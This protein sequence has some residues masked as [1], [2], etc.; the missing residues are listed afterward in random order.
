MAH[1]MRRIEQIPGK[2][3]YLRVPT[4]AQVDL[5]ECRIAN[6]L[7]GGAAGGSKS[8][9]LRWD[10]YYWCQ[11]IPNYQALLMRR[12]FPELEETHILAMKREA[13]LVGAEY[14]KGEKRLEWQ[15]GSFIKAGHCESASDLS[16]MLSREY[17]HGVF[18][19][20]ST[21][22]QDL[23]T[24]I[25]SRIRS[26][27]PEVIARGGDFA[28]Y[29]S[30]PGGPGALY[31]KDHFIT[32]DPDADEFPGYNPDL[33]A[34]IP[35]KISDNP[36]LQA[37]YATRRLAPLKKSRRQQL[38]DGNWDVFGSQFFPTWEPIREVA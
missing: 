33:Y 5:R 12:T 8:D 9:G 17:D 26:D 3:D 38:E 11:K 19:E 16:K 22:E 29:G 36:Y 35:A 4:P 37:D 24:E 25:T 32:K 10:L 6:A 15:N 34:F 1:V 14:S 23:L 18:D 27:K 13:E 2:S 28:R 30:N 20:A 7:F 21:F 31:L